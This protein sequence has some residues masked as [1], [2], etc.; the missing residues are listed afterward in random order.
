[1]TARKLGEAHRMEAQRQLSE[2]EAAAETTTTTDGPWAE[3]NLRNS[4]WHLV[5]FIVLAA[6]QLPSRIIVIGA[7][8]ARALPL[9]IFSLLWRHRAIRNNISIPTVLPRPV[10]S[11]TTV[12]L[13]RTGDVTRSTSSLKWRSEGDSPPR[14]S[15]SKLWLITCG[16]CGAW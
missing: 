11:E 12:A 3:T 9:S 14:D 2:P 8:S 16:C 7:G 5:V 13:R 4:K 10:N 15:R 6:T 1:M